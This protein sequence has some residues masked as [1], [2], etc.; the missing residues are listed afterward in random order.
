MLLQLTRW[1]VCP[2]VLLSGHWLSWLVSGHQSSRVF[3]LQGVHIHPTNY[4]CTHK[5]HKQ[6]MSLPDLISEEP[7]LERPPA[8]GDNPTRVPLDE[9]W[10]PSPA[11]LWRSL[12]YLDQKSPVSVWGW[13]GLGI[14]S[15]L[16]FRTRSPVTWT[17]FLAER[18]HHLDENC[19]LHVEHAQHLSLKLP[20]PQISLAL[21]TGMWSGHLINWQSLWQ[22]QLW[23]LKKNRC[24][25]N[26]AEEAVEVEKWTLLAPWGPETW[27]FGK[28]PNSGGTGPYAAAIQSTSITREYS[29]LSLKPPVSLL[30]SG[31]FPWGGNSLW[32]LLDWDFLIVLTH[33]TSRWTQEQTMQEMFLDFH[34][35][36]TQPLPSSLLIVFSC[37][38]FSK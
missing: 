29:W 14:E 15:R 31:A 26:H 36:V 9:A 16:A 1:A 2:A 18:Q 7:I 10:R 4:S 17:F 5:A 19:P 6:K 33:R 32:L 22:R 21:V 30:T 34:A 27:C 8:C 11:T 23:L 28:E 35:W 13:D 25:G 38:F 24:L 37:F 20:H 12:P 3:C